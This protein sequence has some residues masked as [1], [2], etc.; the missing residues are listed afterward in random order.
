VVLRL[1][2]GTLDTASLLSRMSQARRWVGW[3]EVQLV[4]L[5]IGTAD[6]ESEV[7]VGI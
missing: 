2:C 1:D 7:R 4:M 6:N 5:L 3:P